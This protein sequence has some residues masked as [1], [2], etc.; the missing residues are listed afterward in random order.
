M[1]RTFDPQKILLIAGV[2]PILEWDTLELITEPKRILRRGLNGEIA[3]YV[4][5]GGALA[6]LE[7]TIPAVSP[8]NS[9]MT[10]LE[11]TDLPFAVSMI[12]IAADTVEDGLDSRIKQGL[13]IGLT[14]GLFS[15]SA[16]L[17]PVTIEKMPS[18]KKDR[19][20]GSVTWVMHGNMIS[21]TIGG[22]L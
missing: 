19:R 3:K 8:W 9:A 15:N 21:N 10:T 20:A 17:W 14:G 5:R 11:K 22:R 4:L 16:F 7:L 6:R 12:D 13:Q 18:E 2:F 1:I